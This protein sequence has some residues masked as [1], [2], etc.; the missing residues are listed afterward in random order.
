MRD[1]VIAL[2]VCLA[3]SVATNIVLGLVLRWMICQK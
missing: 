3:L 2:S 1:A